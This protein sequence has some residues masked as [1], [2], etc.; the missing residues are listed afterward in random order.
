VILAHQHPSGC[1][2]PSVADRTAENGPGEHRSFSAQRIGWGE[3]ANPNTRPKSNPH[4]GVSSTPIHADS[5]Q[6][7]RAE[8]GFT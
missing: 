7:M 4:A 2:E 8:T 1:R 3:L 6:P 5:P